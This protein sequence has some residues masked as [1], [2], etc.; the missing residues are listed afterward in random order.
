ME[1]NEYQKKAM[2][3]CT[4]SSNNYS[5]MFINLIGEVGEFAS[6]IAKGVRKGD[7]VIDEDN[8]YITEDDTDRIN[9]ELQLEAGDI[10]WQLSGLCKVMSWNLE[11][12]AQMNIDKLQARKQNG[13]IV[14]D[15]DDR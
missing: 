15:G 10:L 11:D 14:G 3:T 1:L 7:L 2:E 8:V 6:K 4:E 12:I 9:K 13:T 5:Y